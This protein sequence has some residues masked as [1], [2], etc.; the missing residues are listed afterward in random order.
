M[1]FLFVIMLLVGGVLALGFLLPDKVRIER[2]TLIEAPADTV[3][4]L[5]SDFKKWESWSPWAA[6]DPD[7][8]YDFSGEGVGARMVWK[9]D[10]REVGNGAQEIIALQAPTKMV[11]ALDFGE[12]GR[13][14]ATFDIEPSGPNAVVKWSL[15]TNM[16]EGVP[17]H[18]QPMATFMSFMMDKWVGKSYEDGLASLKDRAEGR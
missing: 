14:R 4:G 11:T 13:A 16:R 10:K 2:E 3:F 17:L 15:D 5:I 18:K 9:S 8:E 6:L 7:A 12:M 1:L